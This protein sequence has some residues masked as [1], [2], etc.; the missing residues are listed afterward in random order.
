MAVLRS[1]GQRFPYAAAFGIYTVA[2]L[3]VA[4]PWLL[5][6]VRIPYDSVSQ[7]YPSFAFLARSLAAGQ[8]PFWTPNVYAGWPQIADPQSLIFS[9]LYLIVAL[10][11]PNPSPRLFDVLTFGLL[12]ASGAGSGTSVRSKAWCSCRLRSGCWRALSIARRGS[13]ARRRACSL[14]SL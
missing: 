14:L 1:L 3:A 13:R 11:N 12:Y 4:S 10:F 9:P 2:F 5:D 8:S 7:F 6:F